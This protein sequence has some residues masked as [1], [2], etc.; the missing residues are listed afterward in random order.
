MVT[1]QPTSPPRGEDA[2]CGARRLAPGLTPGPG[3]LKRKVPASG[4]LGSGHQVRGGRRGAAGGVAGWGQVRSRRLPTPPPPHTPERT[5]AKY[6]PDASLVATA[7]EAFFF[8]VCFCFLLF[9][10][11]TAG[12]GDSPQLMERLTEAVFESTFQQP[13]SPLVFLP[14]Q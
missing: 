7:P 12:E 3:P 9:S 4:L 1:P 8:S 10:W 5:R 11:Q 14:F 2:A 6:R 13:A